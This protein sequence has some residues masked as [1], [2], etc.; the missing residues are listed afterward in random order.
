MTN[1]TWWCDHDDCTVQR[2]Q[3]MIICMQWHIII[4]LRPA[5]SRSRLHRKQIFSRSLTLFSDWMNSVVIFEHQIVACDAEER[6]IIDWVRV[7]II[8]KLHK[9]LAVDDDRHQFARRSSGTTCA[10]S[11]M[12]SAHWRCICRASIWHSPFDCVCETY[13]VATKWV[14]RD[15]GTVWGVF[16]CEWASATQCETNWIEYT[17]KH[18]HDID[19]EIGN[20]VPSLSRSLF[21]HSLCALCSVYTVYRIVRGELRYN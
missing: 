21:I 6:F 15:E 10:H 2:T 8:H 12:N 18:T 11:H 1:W 4:R 13:V 5:P 9:H 7:E 20:A 16:V 14:E 3:Q 19:N 17:H